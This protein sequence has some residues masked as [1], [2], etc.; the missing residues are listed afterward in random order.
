MI[1]SLWFS[2]GEQRLCQ[3]QSNPDIMMRDRTLLVAGAALQLA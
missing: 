2:S 1:R 3:V